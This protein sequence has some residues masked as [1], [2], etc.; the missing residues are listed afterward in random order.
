MY[1]VVT[2]CLQVTNSVLKLVEQERNGETINTQ[3]ISGVVNSY[4]EEKHQLLMSELFDS[5]STTCIR[6]MSPVD[7]TFVTSQR[8]GPYLRYCPSGEYNN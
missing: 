5:D 1:I 4:G 2:L 7:S 8:L 3:L 6:A